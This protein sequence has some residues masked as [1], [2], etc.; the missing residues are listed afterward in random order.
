MFTESFLPSMRR[1]VIINKS[2]PRYR[3]EFY[4][5]LRNQLQSRNIEL[6][7]IYGNT[8]VDSR[9]DAAEIEWAVARENRVVKLG[10]VHLI[11]QPCLKEINAADLV[12][13]EQ[14][15]KL[16]LNYIL[17]FRKLFGNKKFAFWGHGLNLQA[18]RVN[19]LNLF[20]RLYVNKPSWWFA[21]TNGVEKFLLKTGFD[22][23][24]ITVVQNAIDT[25]RLHEHYT[26]IPESEI[27]ALKEK[28]QIESHESVCIYCG[29]LYKEKK[30][31]FLIASVETLRAN[32]YPVK[33]III[34][35]GPMEAYVQHAATQKTWLLYEGPKFGREKAMYFR[36]ADL[37]LHP[38]AIGLAILDSFAFETPLVTTTYPFHGPEFHYIENNYNGVITSEE[39]DDY[40]AAIAGLLDDPS[41][42]KKI[43]SSFPVMRERYNIQAMVNNFSNGI[44]KALGQ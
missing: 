1:V 38:G 12:I 36:I 4:N 16:L 29:S 41:K 15:N 11:W 32:G 10:S 27:K 21:Y 6:Q 8:H 24:K 19:P 34:G 43:N 22:K 40:V 23:N 13:V 7:L 20:K 37:F 30:L 9:K 35:S 25:G 26:G 44:E 2:I 5:R 33:L 28:L 39:L 42:I 3:V 18:S 31:E 17:I 14:A